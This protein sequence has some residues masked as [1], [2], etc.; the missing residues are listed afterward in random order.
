VA[1]KGYFCGMKILVIRFSAIGD[2]VLTSPVLR[3][4]HEQLDAEVHFLT[5]RSMLPLVEPNPHVSKVHTIEKKVADILPILENERFDAV[6][7]LHDS[8]RSRQV[9][10]ALRGVKVYRFEKLRFRRWLLVQFKIQV[11]VGLPH[12]AE[13]FLA[14]VAP[15][16]ICDDGKG[17]D[18]FI[19]P[20]DEIRLPLSAWQ[21]QTDGASFA[22]HFTKRLPTER[23]IEICQ[24][25]PMPVVLIGGKAEMATGQQ[26]VA[27][28]GAHVLNTCGAFHLSQSASV[29][30]Q[31]AV[32]IAHD[33]GMMHIAAAFDRPLVSIWGS[34]AAS[35]GFTPF[36]IQDE[37]R[38]EVLGLACRPC[39]KM[40]RAECPKGHF[41][42]MQQIE[43][44][45]LVAWVKAQYAL[46][47]NR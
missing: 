14:T 17:L 44:K 8:L 7:D 16:G 43:W 37:Y 45:P 9:C 11:V 36:R 24:Q 30:R 13:R 26:I 32:V 46:V 29:V 10:A 5:K 2:I 47:T 23:I 12:I 33:T 42:C 20:T 31:A 1:K 18:Y 41:N 35:L 34:T 21:Q 25:L 4:L 3:G 39:T 15:L 22:A 38:A 6:I 40:G 19:P 27:A 28:S